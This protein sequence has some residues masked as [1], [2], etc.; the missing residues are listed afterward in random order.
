[1][2]GLRGLPADS[3][4]L[5]AQANMM[6]EKVRKAIGPSLPLLDL[7]LLAL[8]CLYLTFHCSPFTCLS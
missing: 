7:P 1:M 3:D 4:L 2:L 8:H 6:K 5:A